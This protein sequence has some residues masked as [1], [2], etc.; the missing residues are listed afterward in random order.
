MGA[1]V[2]ANHVVDMHRYVRVVAW[3]VIGMVTL[4]RIGAPGAA[5]YDF[6][7]LVGP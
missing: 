6:P 7:H 1:Q 3:L 5:C 4:A 2:R